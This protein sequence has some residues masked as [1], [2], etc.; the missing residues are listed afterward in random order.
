MM[1]SIKFIVTIILGF[2]SIF[3]CALGI[4]TQSK[5]VYAQ[6]EKQVVSY[7]DIKN[8]SLRITDQ[9][10]R[11]VAI[12]DEQ[13]YENVT[14]KQYVSF[15]FII[16]PTVLIQ[17]ANGKY[18]RMANKIQIDVVDFAKAYKDDGFWCINGAVN[19]LNPKN[20]SIPYSAVAVISTEIDGETTYEYTKNITS[21]SAYEL[22][23]NAV[24]NGVLEYEQVA[25]I[26]ETYSFLGSEDYPITCQN[27]EQIC[28]LELLD[29]G[30][31]FLDK[32]V[33]SNCVDNV[34]LFLENDK[35][36]PRELSFSGDYISVEDALIATIFNNKVQALGV[37]ETVLTIKNNLSESLTVVSN[38]NVC[39]RNAPEVVI[40]ADDITLQN[41]AFENSY[42][43]KKELKPIVT[44]DG[45]KIKNASFDFIVKSGESSIS[46][47]T[48][49]DYA[50]IIGNEG[51]SAVIN[52]KYTD[53]F[54]IVTEKD[55]EI[56]VNCPLWYGTYE[57]YF[58]SDNVYHKG[59]Y[60]KLPK[61]NAGIRFDNVSLTNENTAQVVRL[62]AIPGGFGIEGI[63]ESKMA[64]V[65]Y[66]TLIDSQDN[67]NYI[68]LMI[69]ANGSSCY[70]GVRAS[71]WGT[72]SV[73][74]NDNA[75]IS[76][77]GS[78]L[79]EN[80]GSGLAV[81]Y[82][83]LKGTYLKK[84]SSNKANLMLGIS[85]VGT[86]VYVTNNKKTQLV[87]DLSEYNAIGKENIWTGFEGN[88]V[89]VVIR[90]ASMSVDYGP[91][92]VY[93]DTLGGQT[94]NKITNDMYYTSLGASVCVGEL[95]SKN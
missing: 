39:V 79:G 17:A 53:E 87:F 6:S 1:R 5:V 33:V 22:A 43:D 50:E 35:G 34:T 23:N 68:T 19:K 20:L 24:V 85:V 47:K 8:V 74:S 62:Q 3:F 59:I 57:K 46:V 31:I 26:L 11:W 69:K 41:R 93:V 89:D 21:Y 56:T 91:N 81:Q 84:N 70:V 38:V 48:F 36:Y 90:Y 86:K 82:F 58:S 13:T 10:M 44:V 29:D 61:I 75:F 54:G 65:I 27:E 52:V 40:T 37:G 12:M 60:A 83:S 88:T 76:P 51:G 67:S 78:V 73:G 71:C 92:V 80:E 32:K 16:A 45:Y 42:S 9:G 64:Q 63:D 15:H 4:L 2:L 18:M 49:K 66:V 95:Y 30:K 7:F 55:V 94:V 28:N 77:N 25:K 14:S 72:Y